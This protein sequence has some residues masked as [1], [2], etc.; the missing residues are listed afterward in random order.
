M[1]ML[2]IKIR[3]AQ[4]DTWV[5]NEFYKKRALFYLKKTERA[6][7]YLRQTTHKPSLSNTIN[8][9]QTSR[10]LYF[11]LNTIREVVI[12]RQPYIIS[13]SGKTYTKT[14]F[15]F[16]ISRLSLFMN[17]TILHDTPENLRLYNIARS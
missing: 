7:L 8:E 9:Q 6:C 4:Y 10:I 1:A 11:I 12:Y 5:G 14:S 2:G 15:V 16:L 17:R 13:Q 3:S